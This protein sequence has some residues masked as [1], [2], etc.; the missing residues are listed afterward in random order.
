MQRVLAA[1]KPVRSSATVA[2]LNIVRLPNFNTVANN[3]TEEFIVAKG[4]AL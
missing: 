3:L 2:A 1:A 4:D